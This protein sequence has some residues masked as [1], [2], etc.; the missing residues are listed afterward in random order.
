MP[1]FNSRVKECE[2][3]NHPAGNTATGGSATPWAP[4]MEVQAPGESRPHR[5]GREQG[6]TSEIEEVQAQHKECGHERMRGC[7]EESEREA[8]RLEAVLPG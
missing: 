3:G 7:W 1:P 8:G 6:V 2:P 4:F 5:I